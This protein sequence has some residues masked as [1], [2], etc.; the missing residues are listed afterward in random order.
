[1]YEAN[2]DWNEAL[3]HY[4]FSYGLHQKIGL[5]DEMKT[6]LEDMAIIYEGLGQ[7]DSALK[8]YRAYQ[9]VSDSFE[10]RRERKQ[11]Q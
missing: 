2:E 8:Y 1:M 11:A 10:L 3:H 6:L 4:R 7:S 9:S 5:N